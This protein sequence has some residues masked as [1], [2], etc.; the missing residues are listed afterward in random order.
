MVYR[1]LPIIHTLAKLNILF[2]VILGVST[3]TSYYFNDGLVKTWF[4]CS[5][6]MTLSSIIVWKLTS[7]YER[8]LQGKDGF[9]LA[10]LLWILFAFAAA[11]PI[12]FSHHDISFTDAYFESISGLTTTGATIFP[13]V[14]LLQPSLNLWR[15]LLNWF[16]GMGIIVL[17]V[18]IIPALGIGGMNMFKAEINGVNK[19]KKLSPRINQTAKTLWGIYIIFT[20]IV[21]LALHLAGMNWF[22][23]IC[24]ALSSASLGGFS[25]YNHGIM[26]FNSVKI[27]LIIMAASIFGAISYINHALALNNRSIWVYFKDEE[28]RVSL[29]LLFVS[30]IVSTGYIYFKG[31]YGDG[32]VGFLTT[33][34]YVSFNYIEVGTAGGFYSTDY[35][36]WPIF[37]GILMFVLAN[38]IAN[39]GS[40][41]G[42]IKTLR[43]IIMFKFMYR[44]MI[45]L[46]HPYVVETVKVNGNSISVK[47]SFN[48]M[49]FIL[50]YLTTVL[51]SS[52]VFMFTGV[53]AVSSFTFMV[54]AITN[55]GFGLGDLGPLAEINTLTNFQKWVTAFVMLIGR[56]EIFT[57]LILFLP[58]YWRN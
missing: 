4:L 24:H 5:T 1:L 3:L 21:L 43:I 46:L 20:G 6:I 38:V 51:V 33:L 42:G 28:V 54:S 22:D 9:I 58:S 17:A 34:R 29:K 19:N 2:S 15:H 48:V 14:E 18:A 35:T 8:E 40:T 49:A 26:H 55:V 10:F 30:I 36:K 37:V 57:V 7:K 50:V 56:L 41:G 44:E 13:N 39:A 27:E 45:L 16:G 12:Y 23:A 52:L 31:Y 25:T 47:T 53:D 32:F 11:L